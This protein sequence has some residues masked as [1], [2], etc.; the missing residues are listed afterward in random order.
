MNIFLLDYDK[1]KCAEYMVD[2][3]VVKMITEHAQIL[4]TA[5][6][7][8]GVD[9]GYKITH[10]NH[11]CTI[12]ARQSLSNWL[13]LRDLTKYVHEEWQYRYNHKNNHKSYEVILSLPVPDIDDIGLTDFPQ[14]MPVQYRG[15]NAVNAYRSYY[16][17]DKR[18]LFKWKNRE[19]P[20]WI[21]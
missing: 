11:P 5:V 21:T 10:K 7:L 8:T 15:T 2:S 13:Y 14:A 12:W 1:K 18:H 20:T 17:G 3:H 16:N 6:R 4:S 19:V 9:A